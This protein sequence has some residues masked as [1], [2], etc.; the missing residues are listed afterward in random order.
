MSLFGKRATEKVA[1]P[2]KT[3]SKHNFFFRIRNGIKIVTTVWQ[4]YINMSYRRV[5]VCFSYTIF[6]QGLA[7][8]ISI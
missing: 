5:V 1:D 2:K 6:I 3:V 7:N 8:I 4:I